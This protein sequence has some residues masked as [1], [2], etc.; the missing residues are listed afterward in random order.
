MKI[1]SL[2]RLKNRFAL[3]EERVHE[4]QDK[5]AE[6]M[7]T[8]NRK[9]KKKKKENELDVAWI[10]AIFCSINLFYNKDSSELWDLI[11]KTL[12]SM[13]LFGS[14]VRYKFH[15]GCKQCISEKFLAIDHLCDPLKIKESS[16]CLFITCP[17]ASSGTDL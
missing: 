6:I 8:E 3:V 5:S 1:E 13:Y 14:N 17:H 9:K 16:Y 15:S 10:I 12:F 2:T 4:L 11:F 7:Q